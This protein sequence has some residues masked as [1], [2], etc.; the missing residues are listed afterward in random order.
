MWPVWE[1]VSTPWGWQE[2]RLPPELR[3]RCPQAS[4]SRLW[5]GKWGMAMSRSV[6][7]QR[8]GISHFLNTGSPTPQASPHELSHSL[9]THVTHFPV[10][11]ANSKLCSPPS[12]SGQR[13][14]SRLFSVDC[15]LFS[16]TLLLCISCQEVGGTRNC[17][18]HLA[19]EETHLR[20]IEPLALRPPRTWL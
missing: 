15:S 13:M 18:V 12:I 11:N 4:A 9:P 6:A 20:D 10:Q 7:T 2:P 14:D 3:P 19:D 1:T 17:G 8:L 16:K 5:L